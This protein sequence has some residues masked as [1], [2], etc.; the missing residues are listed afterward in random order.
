MSAQN[1]TDFRFFPKALPSVD[2]LLIPEWRVNSLREF[3]DRKIW[4]ILT[5]RRANVGA[6]SVSTNVDE[7]SFV[8]GFTDW[9]E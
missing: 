6:D 1:T 2:D 4:P 7:E 3:S 9:V 5:R 8:D